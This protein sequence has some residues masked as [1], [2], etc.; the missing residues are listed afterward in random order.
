MSA[1]VHSDGPQGTER[2]PTASGYVRPV[3]TCTCVPK[4]MS[5]RGLCVYICTCGRVMC[6]PAYVCR[7]RAFVQ[8]C[9]RW[10]RV[11][12]CAFL[13][14]RVCVPACCVCLRVYVV[15]V[16]AW[17]R[18][19][20]HGCVHVCESTVGVYCTLSYKCTLAAGVTTLSSHLTTETL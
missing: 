15:C 8:A 7:V 6:V 18:I 17:V 3:C 5:M 1:L 14:T 13:C 11:G 19:R 20:V 9:L 12:V 4:C 16:R 2:E 10:A